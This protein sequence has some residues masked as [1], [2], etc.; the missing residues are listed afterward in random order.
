[1]T[2]VTA[3]ASHLASAHPGAAVFVLTDGDPSEDLGGVR[4]VERPE[5]AD[6]VVIGGAASASRIRSWMPCSVG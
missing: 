1:M 5:D 3:T 2:A 6:V 4:I